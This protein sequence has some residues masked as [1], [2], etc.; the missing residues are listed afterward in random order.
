MVQIYMQ[1]H[2]VNNLFLQDYL[3]NH[4]KFL[5]IPFQFLFI[6]SIRYSNQT[7]AVGLCQY[8]ML[9]LLSILSVLRRLKSKLPIWNKAPLPKKRHV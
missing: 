9:K 2:T 7:N 3:S 1:P 8:P 4:P 5:Y 6:P